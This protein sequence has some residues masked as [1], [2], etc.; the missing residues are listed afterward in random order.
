MPVATAPTAS[1]RPSTLSKM[2]DRKRPAISSADDLAPPSKRVAINGS[3]ARDDNLE[4][5][6]EAWIEVSS[7]RRACLLF[8]YSPAHASTNK[9]RGASTTFLGYTFLYSLI[10]FI[11]HVNCCLSGGHRCW[12]ITLTK[13]VMMLAAQRQQSAATA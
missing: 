9:Q 4:M 5:K 8:F 11:H 3:K 13:P 1:P 6:E 12:M 7:A 10:F 2:E